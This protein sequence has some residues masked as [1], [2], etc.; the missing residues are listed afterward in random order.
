MRCKHI[1]TRRLLDAALRYEFGSRIECS[2]STVAL[3]S[4]RVFPVTAGTDATSNEPNLNS[5]RYLNR[6]VALILV[7]GGGG[8]Q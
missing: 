8:R 5:Q 3:R 7:S 6:V 2:R 1:V 4:V